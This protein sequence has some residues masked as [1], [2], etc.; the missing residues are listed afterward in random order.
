MAVA[1]QS[2]RNLIVATV[3]LRKHDMLQTNLQVLPYVG[4]MHNMLLIQGRGSSFAHSVKIVYHVDRYR[5][6]AYCKPALWPIS[7]IH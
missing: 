5:S 6:I 1:S 4:L 7:C 3:H 2:L